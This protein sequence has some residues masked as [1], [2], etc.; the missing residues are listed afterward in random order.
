MLDIMD[1][2]ADQIND[3]LVTA[4]SGSVRVQVESGRLI[5]T[6]PPTIDIF[7]GATSRDGTTRMFADDHDGGAYLFTVRARFQTNDFDANKRL[8]YEM[9]DDSSELSIAQALTD[10]G[11]LNGLA[12]S[13]D[14][15]DPTGEILYSEFGND[16]IGFQFTCRVLA[17]LS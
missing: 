10:D 14:C 2:M 15:I 13:L 17:A 12:D 3:T 6:S 4:L 9:M 5:E 11:T 7:P 1:A 16:H 8:L